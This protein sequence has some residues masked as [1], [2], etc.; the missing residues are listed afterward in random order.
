MA[1]KGKPFVLYTGGWLTAMIVPRGA[2]GWAQFAIWIAL[3]IPL[4]SWL[5]DH[6]ALTRGRPEFTAGLLLFLAGVVVWLICGL[7]WMLSRAEVI[8][9]V[10]IR[11]QRNYDR[12]QRER[13]RQRE[14]G[15]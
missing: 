8:N 14:R 10:E 15:G 7:W 4:A 13:E 9:M 1:D 5:P 6:I 2:K 3:L 12:I 11:R